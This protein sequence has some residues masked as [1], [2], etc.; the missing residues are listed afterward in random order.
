MWS[1]FDFKH[2]CLRNT[3]NFHLIPG[4]PCFSSKPADSSGFPS[5]LVLLFLINPAIPVHPSVRPS[6]LH[7]LCCGRVFTGAQTLLCAGAE[8]G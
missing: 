3:S 4:L 5:Q 8:S 6:V 2:A 7:T 1:Y